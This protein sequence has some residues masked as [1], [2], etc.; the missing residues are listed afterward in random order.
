MT[1]E[2]QLKDPRWYAL[3]D[4]VLKQDGYTC[5]YCGSRENLQ[6][7]HMK[8][9]PGKMAWEYPMDVLL[10]LCKRCH[11]GEHRLGFAKGS[12]LRQTKSIY[13]V[14]VE[15]IESLTKRK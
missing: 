2:E 3:R 6:V 7:H 11:E 5:R 8:Y 1:Y 12:H 10:T 4:K 13:Q 9:E 15:F 14:M